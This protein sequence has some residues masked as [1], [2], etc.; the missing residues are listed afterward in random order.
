M[1]KDSLGFAGGRLGIAVTNVSHFLNNACAAWRGKEA[2][3]GM[4]SATLPVFL[5]IAVVTQGTLCMHYGDITLLWEFRVK[6]FVG[7]GIPR[8]GGWRV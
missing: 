3:V 4:G 6:L 2:G 7:L 8:H 5:P 1:F